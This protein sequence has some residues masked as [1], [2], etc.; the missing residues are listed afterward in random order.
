MLTKA[1]HEVQGPG[2]SS[3]GA[4]TSY[5]RKGRKSQALSSDKVRLLEYVS[6]LFFPL[7]IH[8]TFSMRLIKFYETVTT[9]FLPTFYQK[10][11]SCCLAMSQSAKTLLSYRLFSATLYLEEKPPSLQFS[12]QI[13]AI[14]CHHL[15]T[16]YCCSPPILCF[17]LESESYLTFNSFFNSL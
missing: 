6:I 11:F 15:T 17:H 10:L 9:Y 14:I 5:Q 1:L 12:S 16:V 3:S 4:I 7:C 8:I 13:P 2:E